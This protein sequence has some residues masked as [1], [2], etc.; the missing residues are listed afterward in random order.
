MF[1]AVNA[2]KS[3][4]WWKDRNPSLESLIKQLKELETI[5]GSIFEK[6]QPIV[7]IY[8]GSVTPTVRTVINNAW[9]RYTEIREHFYTKKEEVVSML[10]K[11]AESRPYRI[12]LIYNT[13]CAFHI[14][15]PKNVIFSTGDDDASSIDEFTESSREEIT[16]V[17]ELKFILQAIQ[18]LCGILKKVDARDTKARTTL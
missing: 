16:T 1:E 3:Y 12:T 9:E 18:Y 15:I 10:R 7:E 17:D 5:V 6:T 14:P 2:V 4:E 11:D 8:E 13:I